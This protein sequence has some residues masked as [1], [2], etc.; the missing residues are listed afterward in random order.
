MTGVAGMIPR[1]T[2]KNDVHKL[3]AKKRTPKPLARKL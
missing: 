1:R 3:A 2:E